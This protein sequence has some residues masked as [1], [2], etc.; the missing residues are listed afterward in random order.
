MRD[1]VATILRDLPREAD[2]PIISKF[3]N[4]QIPIMSIAL[5]GSRS[6]RE[7]TEL[8]DKVIK[9]QLERS[10]G[11][12]EVEIVG[13]ALRAVNVW[14][15]AA[16]LAAY[17]IPITAVRAAIVRQNANI[18]GG[19]VTGPIREDV[20]RT[21]GRIADPK[22]FNDLVVA[23]VATRATTAIVNRSP[24]PPASPKCR[25]RSTSEPIGCLSPRAE[26][27]CCR[28]AEMPSIAASPRL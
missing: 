12:G 25:L 1:R 5:S 23:T 20:L 13:G 6:M 16:R 15:D 8:A 28:I 17:Q 19:N 14:V 9:V 4:D 21:V 10:P 3:D 27:N 18:P 26:N 2:P 11:V 7:L 24:P 22:A